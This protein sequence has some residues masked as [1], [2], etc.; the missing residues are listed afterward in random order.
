MFWI[1]MI[2]VVTFV[3][4][5][6]LELAGVDKKEQRKRGKPSKEDAKKNGVKTKHGTYDVKLWRVPFPYDDPCY[7]IE[8]L[9]KGAV[10][11]KDIRFFHK[12]DSY[13]DVIKKFVKAFDKTKKK[14]WM[15]KDMDASQK[16]ELEAW[17]GD[18]YEEETME[19]PKKKD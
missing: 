11:Y 16:F 4:I 17:D 3:F 8:F 7:R 9:Q 18:V 15:E 6:T 13:T 10:E 19:L 12:D 14:E 5:I 1:F 2:V